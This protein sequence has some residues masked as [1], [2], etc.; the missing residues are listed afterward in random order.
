MGGYREGQAKLLLEVHNERVK[1][2]DTSAP[3]KNLVEYLKIT[4]PN[5]MTNDLTL[6]LAKKLDQA[7]SKGPYNQNYSVKTVLKI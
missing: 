1:S 4:N 2:K 6:K 3:R 7:T 5:K